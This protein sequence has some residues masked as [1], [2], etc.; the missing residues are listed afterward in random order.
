LS[1]RFLDQEL[2]S[3]LLI[4]LLFF[5]LLGHPPFQTKA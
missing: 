4:L 2:I 3:S 1:D 5:L